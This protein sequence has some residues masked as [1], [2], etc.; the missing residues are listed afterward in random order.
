MERAC[1]PWDQEWKGPKCEHSAVGNI[2]NLADDIS[3]ALAQTNAHTVLPCKVRIVLIRAAVNDLSCKCF[4][5]RNCRNVLSLV[6]SRGYHHKVVDALVHYLARFLDSN[7][8]F[9]RLS[10]HCQDS[11]PEVDVLQNPKLFRV[12]LQVGLV[13]GVVPM[14]PVSCWGHV[15]ES[16]Q[17][18]AD[19]Q[20]SI[21]I[22]AIF[23]FTVVEDAT[24][25]I[26]LLKAFNIVHALI[27]QLL[28]GGET[29]STGANHTHA[30]IGHQSSQA[31]MPKEV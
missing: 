15:G 11:R 26:L 16:H 8:P 30:W 12:F 29:C 18:V 3:S 27:C 4:E 2:R 22:N 10:L 20:H 25:V 6:R 9:A 7:V 19:G 17:V 14:E 1:Q 23:L 24:N 31:M 28:D 13:L 21:V 5:T